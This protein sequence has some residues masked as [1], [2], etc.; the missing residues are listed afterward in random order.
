MA[1]ERLTPRRVAALKPPDDVAQIEVW[2]EVVPGLALRVGRGG[3]KTYVV[4]YR[5]AGTHR[6]MTLGRHPR[7]SLARGRERAREV[8]AAAD[9]GRDP[10]AERREARRTDATFAALAREV[11]EAKAATTREA[12]RRERER[13]VASEL[14][15]VWGKKP[16][17]AITRRDVVELVERIAARPAPVMANRTLALVKLLY[18]EGIRRGFPGV[19]ANPAHLLEPRPEQGRG[20]YLTREEIAS[21]WRA[22]AW[23]PPVTRA[24]FRFALLT[25]QRIGSVLRLRWRDVDGAAALWRIPAEVFKGR[26]PHLVPLSRE[27]V[28]VLSEVRELTGAMEYA[29]PGRADGKRPHM[30]SIRKAIARLRERTPDLPRWTVHDFRRTFRTWATRAETPAHPKDP[31]GLGVAPNVADAVLGHVE[32]TL[33]FARYTGEPERYLLAEKRAALEAWGR[34]VLAAVEEF[35]AP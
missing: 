23:E 7:L 35:R 31:A 10:A 15:P 28:D 34:F 2:D 3:T 32:A 25:A 1:T 5:V 30:T 17:G 8:L 20:R 4:R 33:G 18:N 14:L 24:V 29:F 13:I 22:T 27:A 19:D 16:A 21:L 9:A 6:R 12:T 11:L 26:R